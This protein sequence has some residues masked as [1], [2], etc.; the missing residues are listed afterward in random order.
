M[1]PICRVIA[2]RFLAYGLGS[3]TPRL[4]PQTPFALG[5]WTLEK[6]K[7]GSNR[8]QNTAIILGVFLFCS[9]LF[10]LIMCLFRGFNY[11]QI[12]NFD[13][14][15]DCNTFWMI[16]G[17]SK[18]S[19]KPGPSDP[20]FINKTHFNN[21]ENMGTS[22]NILFSYLRIWNSANVW[23]SVYLTFWI[24]HFR[25]SMFISLTSWPFKIWI[26]VIWKMKLGKLTLWKLWKFKIWNFDMWKWIFEHLKLSN[27]AKAGTGKWWRSPWQIFNFLL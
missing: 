26:C 14:R 7:T 4:D 19:T 18:K 13:F 9:G 3:H 12:A 11:S 6:P 1:R 22:L 5:L 23:R 15:T 21:K 27:F 16:S 25:F 10:N 24:C 20:V 2:G 17:T 8:A